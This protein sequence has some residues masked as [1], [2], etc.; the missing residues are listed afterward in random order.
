[1][2]Y[3]EINN[4]MNII[5][6]R[7]VIAR[8]E[9][10]QDAVDANLE[11]PEDAREDF[12]E[13]TDELKALRDLAEQCEGY[14]DW[15]DGDVLIRETYWVLYVEEL[16]K[17]ICGLPGDIPWYVEIDWSTTAEN[18]KTDFMEVEFDGVIYYFRT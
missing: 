14:G 17:D 11:L 18:I 8:I 4:G 15:E 9:E 3:Q 2:S 12:T 13:E 7:D 1:M 6:S 5:D 16:V 10:L